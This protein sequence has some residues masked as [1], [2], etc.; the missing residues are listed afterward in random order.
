MPINDIVVDNSLKKKKNLT[1]WIQVTGD[2]KRMKK[3]E[4]EDE[5]EERFVL[6]I[7][8]YVVYRFSVFLD[9]NCKFG[10]EMER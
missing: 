5:E 2:R 10:V 3:M 8:F 9:P 6:F 7:L 1:F 4:N